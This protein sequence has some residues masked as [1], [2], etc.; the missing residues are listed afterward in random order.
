MKS[1]HG[2][3][4]RTTDRYSFKIE[5]DHYVSG[6]TWLGLDKIVVNNMQADSTY[7]KEYL[8]YDLMDYV[9]VEAPLYTFS[10]ISVNGEVR[11]FYLAV[12]V[13]EDSYAIRVYG[14]D[15]GK[16]YKPESMG[17]RGNGQM[18]DFLEGMQGGDLDETFP[19]SGNIEGDQPS[20]WGQ[21][22]FPP[23]R[24]PGATPGGGMRRSLQ[25]PDKSAFNNPLC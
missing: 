11:G 12:E 19:Q 24:A 25:N 4:D 13:L 23:E 3:Q 14:N 1:Q 17:M 8:S 9:G 20:E 18:N 2:G 22:Q 6:Q 10:N 7:M 5:F 15:H 21:G 16:L